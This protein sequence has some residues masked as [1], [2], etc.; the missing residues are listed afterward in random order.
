MGE[1]EKKYN[2]KFRMKK[3]NALC[4]NLG[5]N[6]QRLFEDWASCKCLARDYIIILLKFLKKGTVA[7]LHSLW[8]SALPHG[9]RG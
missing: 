8:C 9:E 3:L 5:A 2:K 4:A 7:A 1:K 6:H